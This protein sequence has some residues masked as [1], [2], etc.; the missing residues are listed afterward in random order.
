VEK[1]SVAI[2]GI[3]LTVTGVESPAFEVS[4]IPHTQDITTLQEKNA[5]DIVNIECDIIGK[6]I[7]KMM[8]HG[9]EKIDKNFLAEHG[10]M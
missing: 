3:S 6:Y 1:G 10:F 8:Q 4:V 7:E 9:E 5:N 2:D